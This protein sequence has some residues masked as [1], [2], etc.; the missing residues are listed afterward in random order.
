MRP[1][2]RMEKSS[3]KGSGCRVITLVEIFEWLF[4]FLMNL[5]SLKILNWNTRGLGGLEKCNVVKNTIRESRC[6]ICCLQETKWSSDDP[7]IHAMA[8]PNFFEKRCAA[9]LA[10]GTREGVIISWKKSYTY[11]SSRATK[12]TISVILRQE[13]TGNSFLISAVYGPSIDNPTLKREFIEELRQLGGLVHLPWILLGDFNLARWLSDR[14]GDFRGMSLMQL[15]NDL[16]RELEIVDIP[17]S[18]RAFTWSSKR[19]QPSFSR[20]DRVFLSPDWHI[21]FPVVTLQALEVVV[22]DHCPMLLTC[23]Q[24]QTTKADPKWENYWLSY[25]EV[26]L[27][28]ERKWQQQN[29]TVGLQ[30][31]YEKTDALYKELTLW[32]KGKFGRI[33]EHI[34]LSKQTVLLYDKLEEVR[35]LNNHEF[36]RRQSLR[37]TIF[38]LANVEEKK[39]QQRSRCLWLREGDSNTK[40]FHSM[41]SARAVKNSINSIH[42]DGNSIS[43]PMAILNVFHNQ[44]RNLLGNSA[45]TDQFLVGH[46]YPAGLDLSGLEAPFSEEE[47]HAAIK[48]LA[49]NR[50]SGPGGLT[51]EFLKKFWTIIKTDIMRVFG[52]LYG[53][54]LDLSQFNRANIIMIQKKEEARCVKDY[55]PISIIN[56]IPKLISKVLANRLCVYLPDLISMQQTAFIKGRFIAENFI[57]TRELLHHVSRT[58]SQAIFTKIDF[59]KA[60]DSL[61]WGFLLEIMRARS[62]PVIWV[63]WIT[64]IL[65]SASSRVLINGHKSEYFIHRRGLRQGDPISPMLFI[66]AV[67]VLQ[68]MVHVLNSTLRRPISSKITES[69]LALQY[70]DDSVFITN[71]DQQSLIAFKLLLRTF[72][73]ISGLRINFLKSSMVPFNLQKDQ[74]V[75]AEAI[76]GCQRQ[77]LPI[78]YL[79]MPL[80]INAPKRRDF[81]PLIESLE[82]RLQG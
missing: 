42:Q 5:K 60:F 23:K 78:N 61:K 25:P 80:T 46:L 56:I 52:E 73:A 15:F 39:W 10:I 77:E 18:N 6:D 3:L 27:I 79:G 44:L 30:G 20:I 81:L 62:F 57:S 55:R 76:L 75:R 43:D 48:G 31:F 28:V 82:R 21:H 47:V 12:H 37:V 58:K 14:P 65:Q 70:A 40:Y 36:A 29:T 22:S 32:Q 34:A 49:A 64:M 26:S 69:I 50:A 8:L 16:I 66:L 59:S 35:P 54:N 41:A 11:L 9:L 24:R 45:P 67:E 33:K 13:Q 1:I 38:E 4:K 17:L 2:R 51:N 53:G 7:A 68:Q 63:N 74:V 72:T 71:A 19:P